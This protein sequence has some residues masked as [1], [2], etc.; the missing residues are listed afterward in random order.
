MTRTWLGLALLLALTC[1]SLLLGAREPDSPGVTRLEA[2]WTYRWTSLDD[3]SP[4]IAP[5]GASIE[6]PAHPK[7]EGEVMWLQLVLPR[8]GEKEPYVAIDAVRG[9]FEA[10]VD[11][12]KVLEFPAGGI[13]ARGPPAL[14]RQLIPLPHGYPGRL[15]SLRIAA[16]YAP[17]G[18]SGTPLLGDRSALFEATLSRDLPRLVTGLSIAL[19]AVLALVGVGAGGEWPMRLG[20][21]G[22]AATFSVY[23]INSTHLKQS[24]GLPSAFWFAAWLMALV[25]NPLAGLVFVTSLFRA[26][27]PRWLLRLR[28]LHA[29]LAVALSLVF[30]ACWVAWQAGPATSSAAAA[31]FNVAV[32]LMRVALLITAVCAVSWVA[33]L[34]ARGDRDAR[35]LLFGLG[36]VLAF[37]FRDLLAAAGVAQYSTKSDLYIGV[38]C[39][40]VSLFVIVQRRYQAVQARALELAVELRQRA[41]EKE[42]MLRDLHDGIGALT[43]N[44]SMLAEVGSRRADRAQTALESIKQL[45][46][47]ALAELRAFV[48]TSSDQ[49]PSWS[50]LCAELRSYAA[51]LADVQGRAFEMSVRIENQAE[52]VG[53]LGIGFGRIFREAI[54]NA[55]KQTGGSFVRVRLEVGSDELRLEVENDGQGARSD[56][57]NAGLGLPNLRARAADLG[58]SLEFQSG[59]THRLTLRLPLPHKPPANDVEPRR[60]AG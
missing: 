28:Q 30:S 45:S 10:Y 21:A 55:S 42:L 35:T 47:T 41:H 36:C 56:G 2:G 8:G 16:P 20:F 39:L 44:V 33:R 23:L 59:A 19:L 15:L 17:A 7:L 12:E 51:R 6:L 22:Y 4:L 27:V 34:A 24:L 18:V 29:A 49:P 5:G 58:G 25:L 50:E 43:S 31:V 40:M 3:Q 11:G 1:V 57:V 9:P 60:L 48:R 53:S 52:V 14:P 13:H 46:G 54:T 26:A 32:N 38:L 37:A